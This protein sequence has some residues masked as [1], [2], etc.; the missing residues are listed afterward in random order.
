MDFVY[1]ALT[2]GQDEVTQLNY[3]PLPASIDQ[4]ALTQLDEITSGGSPLKPSSAVTG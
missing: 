1:W 2:K 3:S 4:Q